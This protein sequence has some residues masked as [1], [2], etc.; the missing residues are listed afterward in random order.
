MG[1]RTFSWVRKVVL[2]APSNPKHRNRT[3]FLPANSFL[4]LENK[5]PILLSF[6][7]SSSSSLS[8]TCSV[9]VSSCL[10]P[11]P[12]S[13]PFL[14]APWGSFFQSR[15]HTCAEKLNGEPGS[16]L[17]SLPLPLWWTGTH[18]L[19]PTDKHAVCARTRARAA[20]QTFPH[21]V[22]LDDETDCRQQF[23]SPPEDTLPWTTSPSKKE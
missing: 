4:T 15:P 16:F 17:T 23:V 18:T 19:T 10:S 9:T 8:H 6:V 12:P 11:T 21:T 13:A 2:P 20:P 14:P 5:L 3:R 22:D 7:A 1:C